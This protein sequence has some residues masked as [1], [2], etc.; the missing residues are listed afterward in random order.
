MRL[1]L[2]RVLAP[3]K[4][5]AIQSLSRGQLIALRFASDAELPALVDA[6]LTENISK[7]DDKNASK[8]GRPTGC[9]CEVIPAAERR[10]NSSPRRKP[11]E[12]SVCQFQAPAGRQKLGLE[13]VSCTSPLL[14]PTIDV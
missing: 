5:A 4:H 1:R 10:Q 9:G 11:W 13:I 14:Q 7:Q 3:D 8:T 12:N 2:D 6:V